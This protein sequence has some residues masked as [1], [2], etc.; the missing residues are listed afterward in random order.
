M[1]FRYSFYTIVWALGMLFFT[2]LV[3]IDVPK[4]ALLPFL[5]FAHFLLFIQAFVLVF[6]MIVGLSKQQ[7][8]AYLKFHASKIGIIASLAYV[9]LL[10]IFFLL[11]VSN[12]GFDIIP[13]GINTVACFAGFIFFY[14]IH[15][16]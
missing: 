4:H 9:Y 15:K 11:F 13:L 7:Q 14:I 2:F 3:R 10:E 8:F 16:I 6:V 1:F 12:V 5:S